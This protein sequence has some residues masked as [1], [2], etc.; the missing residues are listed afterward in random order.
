MKKETYPMSFDFE[1]DHHLFDRATVLRRGAAAGAALSLAGLLPGLASASAKRAAAATLDLV[2]Y[3]TPKAVMAAE[4]SAF[5]A[6]PQ[7]A[8]VNFVNSFG[9]STS[10]ANAVA[11]GQPAD[12]VFLSWPGDVQILVN[13]GL[14][15]PKWDEQ[16][17]KG[18]VANTVLV[19]ALR[20][21][22]PKKIT[23]WAD[24]TKEG[25]EIITPNPASSGSAKWN[26]LGAYAAQRHLGK[27]D[28]QAV[29]F[30]KALFRNVVAQ[31]PSG[32]TATA[33]FLAGEG[34]VL[35]TFEAESIT[36]NQAAGTDEIQYVIPKQT[37]LVQL[38]IAAMEKSP[39]LY[40]ANLFI[41]YLK[42]TP[43]QVIFG[44]KGFRPVNKA[45]AAQF[46]FPIRPGEIQITDP[47]LGGYAAVQSRW[48]QQGALMDQIESAVGGPT[49]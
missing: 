48:F 18:I 21:G 3:S 7:G 4:E 14:V 9:P 22:N 16:S 8:G 28:A 33:Q 47:V 29:D 17:Y 23:Q 39:N 41:Q 11:A 2:A 25:V 46:K 24:L 12:L 10:Q 15:S 44:Q 43:A 30:V 6:T 20:N 26:I 35:L 40:P 19:F 36:A 38:P 37:M 45:A 13:A 32:S 31:P 5:A 1:N 34:D 42:S 27:T 49:S